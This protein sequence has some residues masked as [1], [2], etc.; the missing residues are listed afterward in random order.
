[1]CVQWNTWLSHFLFNSNSI[2]R[3]QNLFSLIAGCCIRSG[4]VLFSVIC[5]T[6]S[7]CITSARITSMRYIITKRNILKN[8]AIKLVMLSPC[9]CCWCFLVRKKCQCNTNIFI[10]VL[11]LY[12]EHNHK[13]YAETIQKHEGFS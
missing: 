6:S 13:K 11:L 3:P 12:H 2:I 10:F 4:C 7:H 9:K 5:Q 8:Y 1:M